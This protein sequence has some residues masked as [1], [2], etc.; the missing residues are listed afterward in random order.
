MG[1]S[2]V[3]RAHTAKAPS[4]SYSTFTPSAQPSVAPV[5]PV[6]RRRTLHSRSPSHVVCVVLSSCRASRPPYVVRG[7][8]HHLS[9][10]GKSFSSCCW[11]V[12]VDVPSPRSV[13]RTC[14]SSRP[15]N[16]QPRWL[17]AAWY[18][19]PG[20]WAH[21]SHQGPWMQE[22]SVTGSSSRVGVSLCWWAVT[23]GWLARVPPQPMQLHATSSPSAITRVTSC[24]PTF[25]GSSMSGEQEGTRRQQIG[26]RWGRQVDGQGEMTFAGS[27]V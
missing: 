16:H 3:T 8:H 10:R 21:A 6:I 15:L 19:G 9:A 12:Y 18:C 11:S 20:L 14:L 23:Q 25:P 17:D 27:T 22:H 13:L 5:V 7:N 1:Q 4:P 2:F 26:L 24:W